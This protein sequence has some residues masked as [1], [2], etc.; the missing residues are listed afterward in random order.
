MSVA[1]VVNARWKSIYVTLN[2]I[3]FGPKKP[4]PNERL[5]S[6]RDA[7]RHFARHAIEELRSARRGSEYARPAAER[8]SIHAWLS[9]YDFEID[10]GHCYACVRQNAEHHARNVK[11]GLSPVPFARRRRRSL[12]NEPE[13][14]RASVRVY[15]ETRTTPRASS[16]RH[17]AGRE[18]RD[19]RLPFSAP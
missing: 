6:R 11:R 5:R 18:H 2:R 19:L 8:L 3:R 13:K 7:P 15:V 12:L 14:R 9:E 1:F 16:T 17:R 4:R 10:I